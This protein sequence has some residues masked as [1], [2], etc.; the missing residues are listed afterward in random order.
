MHI[1]SGVDSTCHPLF[2]PECNCWLQTTSR[3]AEFCLGATCAHGCLM[4]FLYTLISLQCRSSCEARCA[5]NSPDLSAF[6]FTLGVWGESDLLFLSSP[7][8]VP[9]PTIPP[10]LFPL[11]SSIFSFIGTTVFYGA[12]LQF[13]MLTSR[14][15]L[16][17]INFSPW[18]SH[19]GWLLPVKR[20]GFSCY[21][22]R[23]SN[24][25]GKLQRTSEIEWRK[26]IMWLWG[27]DSSGSFIY[28]TNWALN[29]QL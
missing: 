15:W 19:F 18:K 28:F 12:K 8:F 13:C 16:R 25:L 11:A 1:I 17:Q 2:I 7:P 20:G 26:E 29:I 22:L 27:D 23:V 24:Y 21:S 14:M 4:Q 9:L 5:H 10:P 3:E 6:Q